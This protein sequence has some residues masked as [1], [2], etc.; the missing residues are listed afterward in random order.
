MAKRMTGRSYTV[1]AKQAKSQSAKVR[2]KRTTGFSVPVPVTRRKF[3]MVSQRMRSG[4]RPAAHVMNE[5]IGPDELRITVQDGL[6]RAGPSDVQAP[7]DKIIAAMQERPEALW[8]AGGLS[9]TTGVSTEKVLYTVNSREEV[10]RS[11]IPTR[12]GQEL[13]ALQ[14]GRGVP[15][16]EQWVRIRALV[17]KRPY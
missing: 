6:L 3:G 10:R 16:R 12:R 17:A 4:V 8:T 2:T 15:W 7:E 1:R 14:T 13:F 9:R 11:S 5:L